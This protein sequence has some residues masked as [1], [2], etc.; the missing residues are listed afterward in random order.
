MKSS[1]QGGLGVAGQLGTTGNQLTNTGT[2]AQGKVRGAISGFLDPNSLNVTA[3]TGAFAT[4]YQNQKDANAKTATQ[5][6][7][8]TNRNMANRGMGS[9]PAGFTAA[10]NLNAYFD[11]ANANQNAYQTAV[12][13][14]Q[15]QALQNFW[16]AA[17]TEQGIGSTDIGAGTGALS[18]AGGIYQSLYGT[19]SKQNTNPLISTI[20]AL[21]A[22]GSGVGS[23]AGALK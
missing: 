6:L 4:Q 14:Q 21:G 11:Q 2:Q 3:P 16:N 18:N 10:N 9:T 19:A 5:A 22:L 17:N 15:N 1:S 12:T 8:S 23:A 20:G 13:N 7:A